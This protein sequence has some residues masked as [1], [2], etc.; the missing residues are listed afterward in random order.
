MFHEGWD[1]FST[2]SLS[3]RWT[4]PANK[5]LA[6]A[7][8]PR[9]ILTSVP[10]AGGAPS[11]MK[12]AVLTCSFS[13]SVIVHEP[14]RQVVA[15][16][17]LK[18]TAAELNPN[19][20]EPSGPASVRTRRPASAWNC[21]SGSVRAA[22]VDRNAT[23]AAAWMRASLTAP[24]VAKWTLLYAVMVVAPDNRATDTRTETIAC[25]LRSTEIEPRI[26]AG[27]ATP[28]AAPPKM[29]PKHG[30]MTPV[31]PTS[32]SAVLTVNAATAAS[33]WEM[34]GWNWPAA[35]SPNPAAPNILS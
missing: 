5:R 33:A 2:Y 12:S 6:G 20:L 19:P 32:V 30:G 21:A 29:A 10:I 15:G 28:N 34:N 17:P 11:T 4:V 16:T 22:R 31:P 23:A 14:R 7:V 1:G 18:V 26:S 25:A 27:A 35:T 3:T 8:F 24:A 13:R 9:P